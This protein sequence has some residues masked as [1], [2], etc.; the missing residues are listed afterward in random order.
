MN[1]E[2]YQEAEEV[3]LEHYACSV[4]EDEVETCHECDKRLKGKFYCDGFGEH[5]CK[6]CR[7]DKKTEHK[8]K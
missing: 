2:D 5:L 3:N 7:K 4:C 1:S 6:K 8:T